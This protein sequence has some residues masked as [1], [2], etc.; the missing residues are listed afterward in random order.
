VVVE[1]WLYKKP[2]IVSCYAGVSDLIR[3]GGN[4]LTFDPQDESILAEKIITVL[5]DPELACHLGSSGH[6]KS[7]V[8]QLEAGVKHES[9]ILSKYLGEE[10]HGTG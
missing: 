7:K 8:C 9:E 4:G 10:G 3:D 2:T 1:A 6:R 5:S